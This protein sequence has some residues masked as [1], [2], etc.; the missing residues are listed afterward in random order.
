MNDEG[1]GQSTPQ[2]DEAGDKEDPS[3]A[4]AARLDALRP[5]VEE[6]R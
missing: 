4:M 1:L 6:N 2:T 5:F 3:G